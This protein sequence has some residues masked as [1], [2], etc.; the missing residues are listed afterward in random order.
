MRTVLPTAREARDSTHC[1]LP[2]LQVCDLRVYVS[3]RVCVPVCDLCVCVP[4]CVIEYAYSI[5]KTHCCRSL[6]TAC[7]HP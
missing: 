2:L 7:H 6:L 3:V 4:V 1:T 5:M